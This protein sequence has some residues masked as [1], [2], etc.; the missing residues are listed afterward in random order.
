MEN[1][2]LKFIYIVSLLYVILIKITIL[3]NQL[4]KLKFE[5]NHYFLN[6]KKS[7]RSKVEQHEFTSDNKNWQKM[8]KSQEVF[9]I[10]LLSKF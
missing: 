7:S 4:Q 1:F 10:N 9:E 2:S 8:K 6:N 3:D 5:P